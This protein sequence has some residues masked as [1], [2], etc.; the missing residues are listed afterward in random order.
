MS[1][2]YPVFDLKTDSPELIEQLGSKPKFWFRWGADE[3]PWLFKFAR[4]GTGEH[5]AEKIAAE[6]AVKIELPAARVELAQFSGKRG[7]ASR[8]FV[9]R[10]AGFDL[11]HGDELLAGHVIGYDRTKVFRQS[12]HSINNIVQAISAVFPEAGARDIQLTRFAGLMVLDAL[13]GN[14][15][16]HHQ[17]WG[18]LRG[19]RPDGSIA[20]E[21][22]PSF[23]HASALGRN[24][25]ADER[26]RRLREGSVLNYARKGRGGIYWKATDTKGA[27]PLALV[28]SAARNWPAYFA[29]WLA[30]IHALADG[31]FGAIVDRVPDTWM[32][33]SQKKFCLTLLHATCSELKKLPR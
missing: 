27:N 32:D 21:V 29:P 22:A 24:V 9:R 14:T 2:P 17:N 33:G 10:K 13:I 15:D 8:S 4:E 12:S 3:Q 11:V 26:E 19:V 1:E 18:I 7:L 16:R 6:I 5:W 23:D 20:H 31:D 25:P 30:R 28:E